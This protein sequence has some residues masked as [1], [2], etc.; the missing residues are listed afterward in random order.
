MTQRPDVEQLL[1]ELAGWSADHRADDAARSRARER[2]LRQQA[3]EEAKLLGLLAD[4]AERRATVA[5]HTS[6]GRTHRGDVIGVGTDFVA[7]L[8]H[9]GGPR[10]VRLSAVAWVDA[11]DH[12]PAPGRPAVDAPSLLEVLAALSADSP[13]VQVA[14]GEELIAAELQSV[15]VD[16]AVLRRDDPPAV[17][18]V[19]VDSVSEVALLESG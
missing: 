2:T 15:G 18:Y 12:P 1:A 6:S 4:L 8:P 9:G 19:P 11:G 3:A 10:L 7:L 17:L 16:V 13:R 14:F 5:V